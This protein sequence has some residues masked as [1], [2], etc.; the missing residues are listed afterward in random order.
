MPACLFLCLFQTPL[1]FQSQLAFLHLYNY[2]HTVCFRHIYTE[3]SRPKSFVYIFVVCVKLLS[4]EPVAIPYKRMFMYTKPINALDQLLY[5]L[6]SP[7]QM[8]ALIN[9][10]IYIDGK[11]CES[12]RAA[13]HH[14]PNSNIKPRS[15]IIIIIIASLAHYTEKNILFC[16]YMRIYLCYGTVSL[17]DIISLYVFLCVEIQN[18]KLKCA[19]ENMPVFIRTLDNRCACIVCFFS[20]SFQIWEHFESQHPTYLLAQSNPSGYFITSSQC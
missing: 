1:W 19:T 9:T 15:T 12:F 6:F 2:T 20:R 7:H 16:F 8:W 10:R 18:I 4:M 11:D 3:Y 14:H 13:I 17:F 5:H